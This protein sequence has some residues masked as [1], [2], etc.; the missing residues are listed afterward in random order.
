MPVEVRS[1][2]R[3]D[4]EVIRVENGLIIIRA[5]SPW[6][7]VTITNA[8]LNYDRAVDRLETLYDLPCVDVVA[9]PD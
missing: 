8:L 3:A 9:D 2:M 5:D 7:F 4:G 6:R 1:T